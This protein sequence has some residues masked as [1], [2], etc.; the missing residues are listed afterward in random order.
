MTMFSQYL[1]HQ[2]NKLTKLLDTPTIKF[3]R[4]YRPKIIRDVADLTIECNVCD[5]ATAIVDC[6]EVELVSGFDLVE[7]V[8]VCPHCYKGKYADCCLELNAKHTAKHHT[9]S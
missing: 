9:R 3:S 5:Q 2:A 1:T 6:H 4:V 7:V 8:P